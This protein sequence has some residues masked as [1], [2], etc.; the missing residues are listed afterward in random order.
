MGS[1]DKRTRSG[2]GGYPTF[3]VD[4]MFTSDIRHMTEVVVP[5]DDD[6]PGQRLLL[7]AA[8]VLLVVG[9]VVDLV[10]D[11]PDSIWSGHVLY[12][13]S[14]IVMATVIAVLLW[15]GW[16]GASRSLAD[17]RLALAER[18]AERDAWRARAHAA[19]EGLG[20]AMDEQFDRWGLTPA[21]RD[22]ALRVLKGQSHKAIAY[23]TG[24]SER[25]V[26]QHAAV[27]YRKSGLGGRGELAAYFLEDLMLP[28]SERQGSAVS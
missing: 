7:V 21:E 18:G 11:A 27:V 19:L 15:R 24:R 12:E 28:A 2:A 6:G 23:D 4:A 26:R 16:R 17:A 10:L 22:V 20:Q 1:D 3:D 8:L 5:V 13:V 9:G 14:L 25:T